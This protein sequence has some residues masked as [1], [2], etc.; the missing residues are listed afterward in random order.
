MP[1][2]LLRSKVAFDGPVLTL[3]VFV[4]GSLTDKGTDVFDHG[5]LMCRVLALS[6]FYNAKG[7]A[8]YDNEYLKNGVL[9]TVIEEMREAVHPD[10]IYAHENI[11]LV[12]T[13]GRGMVKNIGT[14][15]RL[16][17][18]IANA[19]IKVIMIDQGSSEL[20]IIVGVENEDCDKCIRAIYQEFFY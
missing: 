1:A 13:V 12:A 5:K 4:P 17:T 11:A 18:A 19:G 15:A 16:F 10:K 20:N 14:S 8:L 9:E 3:E 7:Q 6:T 2:F